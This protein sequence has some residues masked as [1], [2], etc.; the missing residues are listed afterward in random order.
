M[1]ALVFHPSGD[2]GDCRRAG[3]LRAKHKGHVIECPVGSRL[4]SP[5]CGVQLASI[6][7]S[8]ELDPS[9]VVGVVKSVL[10]RVC[11][12]HHSVLTRLLS[13]VPLLVVIDRC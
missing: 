8:E 7:L 13:S 10:P 11:A 6:S 12:S 9:A 4:V 1:L 5:R 3:N 2:R